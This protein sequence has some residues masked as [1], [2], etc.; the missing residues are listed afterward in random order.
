MVVKLNTKPVFLSL[1]DVV[2]YL[3][4]SADRIRLIPRPGTAT[5]RDVIRIQDR[6]NRNYE[7]V[8]GILVEKAVGARESF[9]ALKLGHLLQLFLDHSDLGFLLGPDG[10]LRILP[11]MVRIPDI[12]FISWDQRPDHTI[13]DEPVPA[14]APRL[15]VEVLSE[16]NTEAE[17]SR[18]LRE[19]FES[20]VRIVWLIDPAT[21]TAQLYSSP[22]E[23][24]E[25][26]ESQ[27]LTAEELLP[28]F[29]VRLGFLFAHLTPAKKPA[30]G[31]RSNGK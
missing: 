11:G 26:D 16:G 31:K 29:K 1:G 27:D 7:L 19:Y 8:D 24:V 30:K 28:G 4:V 14:L 9:I 5:I 6:E 22:T 23:F 13:P 15:A 18:K 12:S 25:I 17:M 21:R 20:G 3:G 2:K 10:T